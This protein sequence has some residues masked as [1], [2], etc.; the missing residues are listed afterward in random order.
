M[1]RRLLRADKSDSWNVL[2][3]KFGLEIGFAASVRI[4]QPDRVVGQRLRTFRLLSIAALPHR[5]V[6]IGIQK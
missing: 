6:M 1:H 4:Q 5:I 2:G 3:D